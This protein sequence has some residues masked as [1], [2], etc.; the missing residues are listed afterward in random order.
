VLHQFAEEK[1]KN[2]HALR[3]GWRNFFSA[4]LEKF[5]QP[6]KAPRVYGT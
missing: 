6:I 4:V 2:T 1:K 3:V 5:L